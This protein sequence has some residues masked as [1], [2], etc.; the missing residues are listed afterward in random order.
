MKHGHTDFNVLL[1]REDAR[2][3]KSRRGA[4]DAVAAD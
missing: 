4:K 2:E 3:K 1:G